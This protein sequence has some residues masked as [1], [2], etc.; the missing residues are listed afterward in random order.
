MNGV[1]PIARALVALVLSLAALAPS[2]TGQVV[3]GSIRDGVSDAPLGGTIVSVLL[4]SGGRVAAGFSDERGMYALRIPV[5]GTY[6]V[7]VERI[8]Y[9]AHTTA[10]FAVAAGETVGR[11]VRLMPKPQV[12]A[13]VKV[14]G[15]R[16]CA[17]NAEDGMAAVN[18]WED[19]RAALGATVLTGLERQIRLR[20]ETFKRRLDV[21][22]REIHREAVEGETLGGMVFTSFPP[23][24]L[25][26]DGYVVISGRGVIFRGLDAH[27]I[28]APSFLESHCFRPAP[29]H[30]TNDSLVGLAFEP[31]RRRG[32]VD[33]RGTL[34]L[35]RWNRELVSID[36]TYDPLSLGVRTDG[37]GGRIEFGRL[38]SGRWIVSRWWIRM[39]RI[40]RRPVSGGGRVLSDY[41]EVLVGYDE[42]GGE[43]LGVASAGVATAVPDSSPSAM[44][45]VTGT[46]HDS[47]S[48][49]SLAGAT[50]KVL[51][52]TLTETTDERGTFILDDVPAGDLTLDV[53][54]SR[55]DSLGLGTWS[56]H[57]PADTT[58]TRLVS[59]ALPSLG[60]L[61]ARLCRTSPLDSGEGVLVGR[62][63]A[64]GMTPVA[65]ANVRA[66]W[67]GAP[68]GGA[69]IGIRVHTEGDGSFVLCNVPL[70][71][72]LRVEVTGEGFPPATAQL[73]VDRTDQWRRLDVV[74]SPGSVPPRN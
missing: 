46:I 28:L 8:G 64:A 36:F 42:M 31:I 22:A 58:T 7:R 18:V 34:W 74:L 43:V 40:E 20:Y 2:A 23:D 51:G 35:N 3:R 71:T 47:S 33:V 39:P 6:R 60:G 9:D 25:A 15:D 16:H 72:S 27:V 32:I 63:R 59:L 68:A 69:A 73:R 62:V 10:A 14:A 11:E 21:R 41:A 48:A 49:R 70:D 57:L 38:A 29:K 19:L 50:V 44:R 66:S 30:A 4:E 67:I 17:A 1:P 45:R 56:W 54:H 55:L 5:P 12:I 24:D 65:G 52:T 53:T 61:L 37:V 13:T 26:R